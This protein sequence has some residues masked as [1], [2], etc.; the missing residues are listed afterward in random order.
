MTLTQR[1]EVVRRFL[2]GKSLHDIAAAV[3]GL[4]DPL[5]H[6]VA[7]VSQVLRD[8]INELERKAKRKASRA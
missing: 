6:D 8:H 4:S 1:R 3:F 5:P 7:Y 2:A